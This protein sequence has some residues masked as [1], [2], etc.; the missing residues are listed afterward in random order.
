M[1]SPGGLGQIFIRRHHRRQA[2]ST[3]RRKPII[4]VVEV[5][6]KSVAWGSR[7]L[8]GH[9]RGVVR[10]AEEGERKQH[11]GVL[12]GACDGRYISNVAEEGEGDEDIAAEARYGVNFGK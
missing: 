10:A 7:T 9:R 5:E 2:R 4:K 3:G 6:V 11:G 12:I 1:P 8:T